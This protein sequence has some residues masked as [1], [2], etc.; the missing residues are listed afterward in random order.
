MVEW[1]NFS[2]RWTVG[3]D[4]PG[5]LFQSYEFLELVLV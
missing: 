3:L 1:G 2:G 4:G 5:G